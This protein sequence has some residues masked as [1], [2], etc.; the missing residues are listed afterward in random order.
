MTLQ[1]DT[2]NTCSLLTICKA[3]RDWLYPFVYSSAI[4]SR[5]C[6]MFRFARTMRE[7]PLLGSHVR[8]LWIGPVSV[9][10]INQF[11]LSSTNTCKTERESVSYPFARA[12]RHILSRCHSLIHLALIHCPLLSR[13]Q[14]IDIEHT[15]PPTLQILAMG[16][17]HA[18]LGHPKFYQSLKHLISI[19]TTLL[20]IEL[21]H[22][23][24][25]PQ[26]NTLEWVFVPHSATTKYEW[27]D[28]V[29]FWEKLI[30]LL[31][32]EH[33]T[34][35]KVVKMEEQMDVC[36]HDREPRRAGSTEMVV[37]NR[38]GQQ[39]HLEFLRRSFVG[40]H[41]WTP[42]FFANWSKDVTYISGRYG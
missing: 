41:D 38:S 26:L 21:A 15:F 11:A 23:A 34:L 32:S 7:N 33:M 20:H 18:M 1:G 37:T 24:S 9:N 10:K 25:F 14:W 31:T 39:V 35:V 42:H 13:S 36:S 22:I 2:N 28:P 40:K 27:N 12:M 3:T 30:A 4:L 29:I 5:P 8:S 16:P 17:D 6:T 19:E